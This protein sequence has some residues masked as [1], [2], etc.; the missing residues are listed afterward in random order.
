MPEKAIASLKAESKKDKESIAP[1]SQLVETLNA[2]LASRDRLMAELKGNLKARD[3]VV[4]AMGKK[5]WKD[6]ASPE[7]I[8]PPPNADPGCSLK[9][10]HRDGVGN[11]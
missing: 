4:A 7:S 9:A 6:S 5:L 2:R 3:V 10:I 8:L 11:H 1:I